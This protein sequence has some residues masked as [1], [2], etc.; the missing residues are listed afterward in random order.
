MAGA[1]TVELARAVDEEGLAETLAAHGLA[2]EARAV[3]GVTKLEVRY[4]TDEAERLSADVR[5]ALE[6]WISERRLPLVP[7][8][9]DG[10]CA[11]RPPSD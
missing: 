2:V 5:V 6:A 11:L 8:C 7:H 4:A 1:I 9:S 3:D 10:V